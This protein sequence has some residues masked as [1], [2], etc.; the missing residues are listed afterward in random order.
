[1]Q[2]ANAVDI[3]VPTALVVEKH[4]INGLLLLSEE[5]LQRQKLV[6]YI[7][8]FKQCR[9]ILLNLSLEFLALFFVVLSDGFSIVVTVVV[10]RNCLEALRSKIFEWYCQFLDLDA[11][12]SLALPVKA[13]ETH[14]NTDRS[15]KNTEDLEVAMWS[16]LKEQSDRMQ[17]Y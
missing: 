17:S 7:T 14:K 13:I 10:V 9:Y 2:K 3:P 8:K 6:V 12:I 1:M 4:L 11:Y 5:F 15:F 16:S